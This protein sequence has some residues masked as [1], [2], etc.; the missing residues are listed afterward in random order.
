VN[1]ASHKKQD[2]LDG[3]KTQ[4][5]LALENPYKTAALLS[6]RGVNTV[7]VPTYSCTAAGNAKTLAS[8]LS[9]RGTEDVVDIS[10]AVWKSSDPDPEEEAEAAAEG[11]AGEEGE[12]A[13]EASGPPFSK[14]NFVVYGLPSVSFA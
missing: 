10:T 14:F 9:A 12:V 1:E 6:L 7:V 13:D 4:E 2:R 3:R 11:E 5:E 8:V